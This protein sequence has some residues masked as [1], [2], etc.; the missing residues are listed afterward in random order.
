MADWP[1]YQSH[2]IIQAAVI[3]AFDTAP[4]IGRISAMVDPGDGQTETFVPTQRVMMQG[5][6]VGD[7]AIHYPDGYRS[8]SPKAVFEE[9]YSLCQKT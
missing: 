4:G 2:K 8:I 3:I 6:D 7:Y 5:A 1:K 9:G